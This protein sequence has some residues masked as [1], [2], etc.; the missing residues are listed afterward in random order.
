MTNQRVIILY[1]GGVDSTL[2]A[3]EA[4]AQNKRVTLLHFRYDHPAKMAEYTASNRIYDHLRLDYPNLEYISIELPIMASSM[5]I[6]EGKQGARVVANRNA[7]MLNMAINICVDRNIKVIQYGAVLDDDAEYVDC[8]PEFLDKMNAIA[9]DWG[10]EIQAP[11]MK[12]TKAEIMKDMYVPLYIQE[13]WSS[14]YQ[15]TMNSG[16]WVKCGSCSSCLSNQ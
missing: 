8:R 10:V 12:R 14:C 9:S 15:P 6:G 16:W 1:S 13:N 5:F 11:Y 4:L 3:L 7:I 2:L